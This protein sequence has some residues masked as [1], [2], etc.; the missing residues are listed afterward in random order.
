[1]SNLISRQDSVPLCRAQFDLT[2]PRRPSTAIMDAVATAADRSPLE[3]EPLYDTIELE[4]LDRLFAHAGEAGSGL[5]L[6]FPVDEWDLLVTGDG[7]VLVFETDAD[8]ADID[9][10]AGWT[11]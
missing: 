6:E 5:A 7:Q 2:G 8:D 11:A 3:I 1:M 4:A 10:E 9:I